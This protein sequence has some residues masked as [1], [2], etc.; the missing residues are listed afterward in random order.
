MNYFFKKWFFD[1]NVDE[2][3]YIYFI[4]V[5]IKCFFFT[6]RNFTFHHYHYPDGSITKSKTMHISLNK[7]DWENLQVK[8]KR[9]QIVPGADNLYIISEFPDLEINLDIKNYHKAYSRECFIIQPKNKKI[10]WFPVPLYMTATGSIEMDQKQLKIE[11]APVYIDHV[12][13]DILPFNT[14]VIKMYWG[15]WLHPDFLLSYSIVFTPGGKEWSECVLILNKQCYRFTDLQYI[16]MSGLSEEEENEQD[17]N[18]Y[19]LLAG[20][21]TNS[22]TMNIHHRRTAAEGAFI[23]PEQYKFK[24]AYRLLNKISK[25][26]RGKKFI[27]E[28]ELTLDINRKHY[29][30]QKLSGIDEYVLF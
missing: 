17:E 23:D 13:S 6:I 12:T 16:R 7:G 25:N 15:R 5:E 11:D 22:L 21:G 3:T 29:E 20:E 14:P 28:A 8:G 10:T 2:E 4:L 1:L 26:P 27:S 18:S 9:L 30:W 24:N 19:Q